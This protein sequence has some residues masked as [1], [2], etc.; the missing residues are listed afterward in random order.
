MTRIDGHKTFKTAFL[1][2]DFRLTNRN[3]SFEE[4]WLASRKY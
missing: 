1:K 3:R 2:F 4:F